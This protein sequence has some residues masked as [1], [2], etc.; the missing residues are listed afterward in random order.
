MPFASASKLKFKFKLQKM[1]F[2]HNNTVIES[3]TKINTYSW[4]KKCFENV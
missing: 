2:M 1:M 4:R 3:L